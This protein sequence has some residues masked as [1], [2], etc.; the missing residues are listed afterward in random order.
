MLTT[1]QLNEEDFDRL[2]KKYPDGITE[3]V[4]SKINLMDDRKNIKKY[5]T[6]LNKHT[7]GL[8]LSLEQWKSINTWVIN[9]CT[10]EVIYNLRDAVVTLLE[11]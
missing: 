9:N 8:K 10:E 7:V 1:I 6:G 5:E 4:R 2:S 11:E 3:A